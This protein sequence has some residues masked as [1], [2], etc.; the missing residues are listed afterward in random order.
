MKSFEI[1]SNPKDV[2][3]NHIQTVIIMYIKLYCRNVLK[4]VVQILNAYFSVNVYLCIILLSGHF[5]N[6]FDL[7]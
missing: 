5:Q 3:P 1:T 4:I 6:M 7:Q 2:Y